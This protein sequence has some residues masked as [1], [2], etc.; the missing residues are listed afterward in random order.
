M[1]MTNRSRPLFDVLGSGQAQSRTPMPRAILRG[2]GSSSIQTSIGMQKNVSVSMKPDQ[3][4]TG[5]PP[6]LL[7]ARS[8][9][10]GLNV[11]TCQEQ[12]RAPPRCYRIAREGAL[13]GSD[14]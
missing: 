11:T 7:H 5:F 4:V 6:A 8:A 3:N 2:L 14:G 12:S 9:E 13:V 10:Q 1:D